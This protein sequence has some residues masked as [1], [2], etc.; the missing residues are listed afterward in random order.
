[1]TQAVLAYDQPVTRNHRRHQ[2]IVQVNFTL[3]DAQ[4]FIGDIVAVGIGNRKRAF[5]PGITEYL[6]R[7][8]QGKIAVFEIMLETGEAP[9]DIVEAR[10][11]YTAGHQRRVAELATAIAQEMAFTEDQI[12]GL[13]LAAVVHDLGKIRVPAEILAKPGKLTEIEFKLIQ[14]HPEAGY[15]ILKNVTFPGRLPASSYSTM[16]NWTVPAIRRD[17]KGSKS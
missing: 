9:A 10:D 12:S 6:M 7:V 16:K 1:M 5:D 8:E 2:C 4:D 15:D 3:F 14:V 13:H 17:S 11:P